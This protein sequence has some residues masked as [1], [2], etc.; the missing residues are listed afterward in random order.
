MPM[1]ARAGLDLRNDLQTQPRSP[2]WVAETQA[3][4]PS[5][6]ASQCVHQQEGRSGSQS[7]DLNTGTLIQDTGVPNIVSTADPMAHPSFVF[8]ERI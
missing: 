5:P 6:A 4:A 8:K 3:L 2:K 7:R 1:T